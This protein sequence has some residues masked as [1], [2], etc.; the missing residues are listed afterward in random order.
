MST[1]AHDLINYMATSNCCGAAI[2]TP[3]FCAEC[4]EHC[5]DEGDDDSDDDDEDADGEESP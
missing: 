5:E 1:D 3:D 4:G 2:I